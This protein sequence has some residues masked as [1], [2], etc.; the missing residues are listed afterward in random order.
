MRK[1]IVFVVV[2]L[3]AVLPL[4]AQAPTR[5]CSSHD[6]A[7]RLDLVG[8]TS[9]QVCH[10]HFPHS[11][12]GQTVSRV[13]VSTPSGESYYSPE[14]QAATNGSIQL[15]SDTRICTA[16]HDGVVGPSAELCPRFSMATVVTASASA[17]MGCTVCHNPHLD[18][19]I[20]TNAKFLRHEERCADC[21]EGR[22][23]EGMGA[24]QR[25][26]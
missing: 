19:R 5:D 22:Q 3:G 13:W 8:T 9:C 17:R 23:F 1:I 2:L 14:S 24:D 7:C 12:T 25:V 16:C 15:G 18:N 10:A 26:G 4:R 6:H 20:E 21:H 11:E